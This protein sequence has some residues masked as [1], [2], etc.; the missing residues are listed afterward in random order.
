MSAKY[1]KNNC[2]IYYGN[3]FMNKCSIHKRLQPAGTHMQIGH[4]LP[5]G[6]FNM[7]TDGEEVVLTVGQLLELHDFIYQLTKV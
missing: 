3:E 1:S 2:F 4:I 6:D 7:N 5:S